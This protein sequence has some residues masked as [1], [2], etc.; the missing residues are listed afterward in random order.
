MAS[1][2]TVP[3]TTYLI[4]SEEYFG[5]KELGYGITQILKSVI[6]L[7]TAVVKVIGSSD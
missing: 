1:W 5:S 2:P 4:A 7:A 6:D 3:P